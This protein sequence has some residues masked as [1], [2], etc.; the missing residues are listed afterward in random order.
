MYQQ[1]K[2]YAAITRVALLFVTLTI[3]FSTSLVVTAVRLRNA[4]GLL[5][6]TT[7]DAHSNISVSASAREAKI[8]G[9]GEASIRIVP[10]TYLVGIYSS[11]KQ[12]TKVVT[13]KAN[14]NTAVS[15]LF[16]TS[17]KTPENFYSSL[18]LVGPAAA[19]TIDSTIESDGQG[20]R[21]VVVISAANQ[22]D[23]QKAL[24][25]ITSQGYILKDFKI[26]FVQQEI[27][28]Y[29]YTDGLPTN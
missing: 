6:I 9:V 21:Q 11:G 20:A 13:V 28:N 18:P 5:S 3:L 24:D 7:N 4:T 1:N 25:Y 2:H 22:Q 10:G 29:H 17:T 16:N 14:K 8:I 26:K 23:Y 27:N 19:Y 12:L 15:L